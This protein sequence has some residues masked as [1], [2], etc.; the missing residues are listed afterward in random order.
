[1]AP[2]SQA[3][4]VTDGKERAPKFPWEEG[5]DQAFYEVIEFEREGAVTIDL[6]TFEPRPTQWVVYPLVET[7]GHTRIIAPGD[8]GKSYFALALAAGVATGSAKFIGTK[9]Q[10]TGPVLY[11]DW[12]TDAST[13]ALR[14]QMLC[15]GAGVGL[16]DRDL[17]I[18]QPHTAPL[19]RGA[20][21]VH[22]TIDRYGVALVVVD[23]VMLARG[24]GGG[25]RAEDSAIRLFEALRGFTQPAVLIDHKA[26]EAIAKGKRGGYG[27]VVNQNSV[28][29]EWEM[30]R[31]HQITPTTKAFALSLEKHNNT[32]RMAP[33]GFRFDHEEDTARFVRVAIDD[34]PADEGDLG[35]RMIHLLSGGDEPL[36]VKKIADMLGDVSEGTVRSRLN[37]DSRFE[38]RATKGKA[39]RW[40][41]KDEYRDE[42]E[43]AVIPMPIDQEDD[44][45]QE[46][47]A[48]DSWNGDDVF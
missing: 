16:P 26:K 14:L 29:L 6:T 7:G 10:I 11:L 34:M 44:P 41:V 1:M 20:E 28:R 5:L 48:V 24:A 22:R 35:E 17:L 31:F 30:T 8:S 37:T 2:K 38:N 43:Q 32:G 15:K 9:P 47:P 23:S 27:S 21:Q 46:P 12:E 45:S 18:Y 33:M 39:G 36:M 42:G 40:M 4:F 13:H 25:D 3:S 19:Y